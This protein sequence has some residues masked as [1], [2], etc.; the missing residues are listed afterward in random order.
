[1]ARTGRPERRRPISYSA[2]DTP[3]GF[4]VRGGNGG[5]AFVPATRPNAWPRHRYAALA[6]ALSGARCVPLHLRTPAR[7]PTFTRRLRALVGRCLRV[8]R[9]AL[10]RSCVAPAPWSHG[11]PA[12]AAACE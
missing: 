11:T 12:A 9:V 5:C 8:W 2:V 3:L 7:P 10:P 4:G 1:V 6:R